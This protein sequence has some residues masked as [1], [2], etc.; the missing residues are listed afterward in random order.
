ME[1]TAERVHRYQLTN[2]FD[3]AGRHGDMQQGAAKQLT[4]TD[5]LCNNGAVDQY[6]QCSVK[7]TRLE[8]VYTE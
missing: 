8:S 1:D 4:E 5:S 6:V 7:L 3:G 2:K